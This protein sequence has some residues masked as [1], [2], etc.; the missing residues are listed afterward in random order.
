MSTGCGASVFYRLVYANYRLYS[1]LMNE[2][3][4]IIGETQVQNRRVDKQRTGQT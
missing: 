3:V 4:R 2:A 1:Y